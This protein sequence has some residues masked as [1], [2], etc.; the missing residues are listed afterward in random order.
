V[1]IIAIII[2]AVFLIYCNQEKRNYD[3]TEYII[4]K[5]I[6]ENVFLEMYQP[7]TGGVLDGNIYSYYITDST[8]FRKYIGKCDDKEV[9]RFVVL[10][11]DSIKA[12][13]W[14]W[15]NRMGD[16]PEIPIDSVLFSIKELKRE[17]DFE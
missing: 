10:S 16:L 3:K 15:R 2:I 6:S 9:Y 4:S 8:A 12:V 7:Y 17:A 11:N 14:S 13:K 1:V 5:K